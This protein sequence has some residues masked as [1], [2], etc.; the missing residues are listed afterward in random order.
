ML[1]ACTL[2]FF[3]FF[4]LLFWR[5]L[6]P[7]LL[8][9][10]I[11]CLAILPLA[12]P[13]QFQD[14]RGEVDD[15]YSGEVF[16]GLDVVN[17]FVSGIDCILLVGLVADCELLGA[18]LLGDQ[19]DLADYLLVQLFD[20]AHGGGFAAELQRRMVVLYAGRVRVAGCCA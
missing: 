13:A 1:S 9:I 2:I 19:Q 16:L 4:S 8:L 17:E 20:Y 14:I 5:H 3:L 12:F 6:S 10:R 15:I 11:V 18:L 7:L